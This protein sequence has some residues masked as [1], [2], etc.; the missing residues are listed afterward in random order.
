MKVLAISAF[1]IAISLQVGC[2]VTQSSPRTKTAWEIANE[3]VKD[4]FF[5]ADSLTPTEALRRVYMNCVTFT[6]YV[7]QKEICHAASDLF[8]VDNAKTRALS[9]EIWE[10]RQDNVLLYAVVYYPAL[11]YFKQKL[12][13]CMLEANP[14]QKIYCVDMSR[15]LEN[16]ANGRIEYE[17]FKRQVVQKSAIAQAYQT[18]GPSI[19]DVLFGAM[20]IYA[21]SLPK[22]YNCSGTVSGNQVYAQCR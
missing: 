22:T 10:G 7:F 17:E 18:Q 21:D 19:A 1:L 15:V 4:E 14:V 3:V 9:T 8:S 11:S 12:N 13:D 5:G 6:E 16:F 20:K 2:S